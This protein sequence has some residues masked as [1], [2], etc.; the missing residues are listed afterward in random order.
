MESL[1]VGGIVSLSTIDYP[2]HLATVIF[3]QGCPWRCG[4][5]H[6]RHLQSIS[7]EEA[8]PWDDILNLLKIRQGFVEAAVFSGGEPLMQTCLVEA[9]R[10]VKDMGFK[11]GLHTSGAFPDRFAR[12][13]P[14]VDWVGFDIKHAFERYQDVT[15]VTNSGVLARESLDLLIASGVD[16]EVRMTLY[17]KVDVPA[18][19][20]VLKGISALGVKT[21]ALQKCRDKN[22]NIVEHPIFSDKLLLEDISKYFNNFS[23]RG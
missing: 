22:E 19:V 8:L 6:N 11:I 4:Y 3:F 10:D 20:G 23:I 13:L 5:C 2:G 15:C 7:P 12:V 14:F 17:E 16:F 21:V 9:I 1:F 18:V